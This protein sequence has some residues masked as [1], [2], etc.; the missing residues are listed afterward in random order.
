MILQKSREER[1]AVIIVDVE[2]PLIVSGLRGEGRRT[3]DAGNT[4]E[5]LGSGDV[6]VLGTPAVLAVI[7]EAAVNAIRRQVPE[8]GTS[9]G[10]WVELE[11]LAPSKIGAEVVATAVLTAVEGR[12]LHFDCEVHDGGTLVARAKHRR[13]LVIRDRW[14]AKA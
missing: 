13:Y 3:V 6:P 14:L 10:V 4:A 8:G 9:V 12:L 1:A 5:A 11:H 2:A 7:E